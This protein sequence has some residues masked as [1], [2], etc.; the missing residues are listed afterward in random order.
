MAGLAADPELARAALSGGFDLV[1][2]ADVVWLKELVLPLVRAMRAVARVPLWSEEERERFKGSAAEAGSI[3]AGEELP[4]ASPPIL[5]P[6]VVPDA[7]TPLGL[8]ARPRTVFL[9]AHQTRSIGADKELFSL[10]REAGFSIVP[11]PLEL[12]HPEYTDRDIQLL[13]IVLEKDKDASAEG[14]DAGGAAAGIATPSKWEDD[15]EL[16]G[17]GGV[18]D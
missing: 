17:L 3:A 4:E 9:V 10:L 14:G 18:R 7:E 2:G 11:L 8:A 13:Q 6:L 16:A 12:L 15:S 5:P 1:L